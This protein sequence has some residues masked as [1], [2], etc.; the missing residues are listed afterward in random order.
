MKKVG[1]FFRL[2]YE[3]YR[4]NKI[5]AVIHLLWAGFLVWWATWL[6]PALWNGHS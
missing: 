2:M 4:D 5:V 6:F 3:A 1:D